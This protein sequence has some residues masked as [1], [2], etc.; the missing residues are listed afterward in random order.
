MLITLGVPELSGVTSGLFFFLTFW[1]PN[2][3]N[4][5]TVSIYI[6]FRPKFMLNEHALHVMN[7]NIG[8]FKLN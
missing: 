8:E 1:Y 7:S 3:P 2:L 6:H 4:Y 5:Y